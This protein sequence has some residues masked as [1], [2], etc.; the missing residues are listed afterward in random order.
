LEDL[1][2]VIGGRNHIAEEIADSDAGIRGC[3]PG[4]ITT[5]VSEP[6]F[7]DGHFRFVAQR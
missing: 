5:L 7:Q 2:T 6:D 3:I 1:I 4:A